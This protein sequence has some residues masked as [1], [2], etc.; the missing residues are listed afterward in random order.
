M[1]VSSAL[2]TIGLAGFVTLA[3]AAIAAAQESPDEALES[4]IEATLKKDSILAARSIDV[5]S[6]HGRVKLTGA[7]KT[8]DEKARAEKLAKIA[9]VTG[10]VNELRID[11]NAD[12][13]TADR[14]AAA[15][16]EGLD[17]AVDATA[18]GAEKAAQGTRRGV[19]EAEK[20]VGKAAGKTAEAVGT[21]GDKL[22]DTS[23]STRV[24]HEFS[25]DALLKNA[26][27]KV[28]TKA[29]VVT[30]RGTVATADVKARAEEVATR[31]EG[32]ARVVNEIVVDKR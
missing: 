12:R 1:K 4:K 8:A 17:K 10:V 9:G 2:M 15:T 26:R 6:E 30:L 21:A 28:D 29:R 5:E 24:T 14:A 3:P 13:S 32:V 7:V 19:A 18:K 22:T 25:N 27:V 20:G 31:T 11:P 16:K 23:I